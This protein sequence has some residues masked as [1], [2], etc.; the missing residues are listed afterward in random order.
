MGGSIEVR[1]APEV[2][3]TFTV[4][5]PRLAAA[6]AAHEIEAARYAAAR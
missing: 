4:R 5:I 6:P 2:G 1:S 3:S